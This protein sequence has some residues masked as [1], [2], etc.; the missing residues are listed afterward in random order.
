M[1][2]VPDAARLLKDEGNN[3][4]YDANLARRAALHVLLSGRYVSKTLLHY[5][6]DNNMLSDIAVNSIADT[7]KGKKLL[8]DNMEFVIHFMRVLDY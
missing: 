2:L 8:H 1:V 4:Y 7:E 5:V 3:P 6:L